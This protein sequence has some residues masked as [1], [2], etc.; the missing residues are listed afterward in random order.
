MAIT[1]TLGR[2]FMGRAVRPGR[3][4]MILGEEDAEE[5]ARRVNAVA[6]FEKYDDA[7]KQLI[8]ANIL[9]FSLVGCDV[10]LTAIG[11][12]GLTEQEFAGKIIARAKAMGGVCLIVLDHLALIHGGDFNAREDAS[13]TMRVVNHIAQETGRQCWFWPIHPRARKTKKSPM[14]LWW[15]GPQRLWIRRV[16]LGCSQLCVKAKARNSV[17]QLK[18]ANSMRR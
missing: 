11:E 2:P 8:E 16:A 18:T 9:A 15:Q 10:R 7:E 14:R 17:S 13:L 6:R 1:T 12:K 3:A 4:M 5:V